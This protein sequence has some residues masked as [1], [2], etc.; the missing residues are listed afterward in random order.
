[1]PADRCR[2]TKRVETFRYVF[3]WRRL[4]RRLAA[5]ASRL[6]PGGAAEDVTKPLDAATSRRIRP[7]TGA[8]RS[9]HSRPGC[10]SAAWLPRGGS[11]CGTR[12]G[13]ALSC[14]LRL[15]LSCQLRLTPSRIGFRVA[16]LIAPVNNGSGLCV[17]VGI[18]RRIE[19]GSGGGGWSGA[20]VFTTHSGAGCAW[21]VTKAADAPGAGSR[22]RL[23]EFWPR[24]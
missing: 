14:Q 22:G 15:T 2:R 11:R 20:T 19:E 1:M 7:P 6:R 8:L 5:L 17:W 23:A 16:N 13:Q 21:P 24:R 18:E 10:I 3:K 12:P 4:R 9:S